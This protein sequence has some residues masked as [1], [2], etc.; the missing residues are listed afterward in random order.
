[1]LKFG[2]AANNALK[3]DA[4]FL[5]LATGSELALSQPATASPF[6]GPYRPEYSQVDGTFFS[7]AASSVFKVWG[8]APR[9]GT[10]PPPQFVTVSRGFNATPTSSVRAQT[11]QTTDNKELLYSFI[12]STDTTGGYTLWLQL[13]G[14]KAPDQPLQ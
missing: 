4:T 1:M 5:P 2:G 3:A 8:T 12:E 14:C 10:T 13:A 9:C 7:G 6:G 11:R